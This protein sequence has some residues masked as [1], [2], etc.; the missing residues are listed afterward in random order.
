MTNPAI[1]IT[2]TFVLKIDLFIIRTMKEDGTN[3]EEGEKND[4]IKRENTKKEEENE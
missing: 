1:Y 2:K 3:A 4:K